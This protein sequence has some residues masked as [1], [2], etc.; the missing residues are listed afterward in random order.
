ME[1]WNENKVVVSH[2]VF[3]RIP[4]QDWDTQTTVCHYMYPESYWWCICNKIRADYNH[5]S[6]IEVAFRLQR[7]T[8]CKAKWTDIMWNIKK[9]TQ[10]R[11]FTLK[12]NECK[13]RSYTTDS[14]QR[15]AEVRADVLATQNPPGWLTWSDRTWPT[16][17][18]NTRL[19]RLC[20]GVI[21][22]V[23]Q[24]FVKCLQAS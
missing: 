4:A 24:G 9:K 15:A 2:Y 14:Q 12:Y 20:R 16:G 17:Y 1:M 8:W 21:G 7:C 13:R 5:L 11:H 3:I 18:L 10:T 23:C 19:W 6:T 22:K